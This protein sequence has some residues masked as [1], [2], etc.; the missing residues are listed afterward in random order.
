MASFSASA[1]P[2]IAS[3]SAIIRGTEEV[4]PVDV[5]MPRSTT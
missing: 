1:R 2:L 4:M 3:T 5:A